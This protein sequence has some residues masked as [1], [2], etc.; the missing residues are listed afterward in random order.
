MWAT[1]ERCPSC[2]AGAS[3]ISTAGRTE[4][5][6][7]MLSMPQSPLVTRCPPAS[8]PPIIVHA[9]PLRTVQTHTECWGAAGK[10]I[11]DGALVRRQHRYAVRGEIVRSEAA[12]HIGQLDRDAASEAGH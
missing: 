3:V 8:R 9:R 11:L 7:V 10:D 1:R 5:V 12:E 4:R 6:C 2:S